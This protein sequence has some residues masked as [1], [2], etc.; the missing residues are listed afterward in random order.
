MTPAALLKTVRLPANNATSSCCQE[1]GTAY[2]GW[3]LRHQSSLPTLLASGVS[4]P[5]KAQDAAVGNFTLWNLQFTP[6]PLP[7]PLPL[8]VCYRP[9]SD[10]DKSSLLKA[11]PAVISLENAYPYTQV[12]LKSR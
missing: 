7:L 1:H 6:L 9:C 2:T 12:I 11:Q 3:T 5:C 8:P 4:G 10:R